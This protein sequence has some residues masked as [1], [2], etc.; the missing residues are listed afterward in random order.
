MTGY[1]LRDRPEAAEIATLS[2]QNRAHADGALEARLVALRRQAGDALRQAAGEL[3]APAWPD[4]FPGCTSLPEVSGAELDAASLGGALLHHGGLL[5]RGLYNEG[6]LQHLR[7]LAVQQEAADREDHSPLGTSP[8][9]LFELLEAYRDSGLLAALSGYLD[10]QPL[11]FAERAKLRQHRAE[12][13]KFA[14]IPWHQ[15]ASFFGRQS[16][17][18]NCWAAVTPCGEGNPGLGIIPRRTDRYHGWD[19]ADGRAPLDYGNAMPD[20]EL[21]R[22]CDGHPAVEVVLQPGDALLFDE[23][24]VHRTN[25]RPWRLEQQIVTISWFFRA[26]GFPDWGTPLAV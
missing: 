1:Q 22:L 4:A 16:W 19:P 8:H 6:Q 2:E 12:T 3:Q 23:M 18:V 26:S 10:G 15:D 25:S 13:H 24:T 17:A 20:E 7:Q 5:V 14:A 11:M 9:T 21:V